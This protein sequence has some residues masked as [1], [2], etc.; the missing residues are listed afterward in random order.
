MAQFSG[1]LL[2]ELAKYGQVYL[3]DI[4]NSTQIQARKLAKE[5]FLNNGYGIKAIVIANQQT[6]GFGRFGRVWYSPAQGLYF[7]LLVNFAHNECPLTLWT[8]YTAKIIAD[9]IEDFTAIPIYL[10]W[11]NDLV[12]ID[13]NYSFYKVGGILAETIGRSLFSVKSDKRL[14]IIGVG[15]NINQT[16]FPKELPDATS[17]KLINMKTKQIDTD[18]NQ[19]E[20]LHQILKAM[21]DGLSYYL[22]H[23]KTEIVRQ[24]K[25]KSSVIGKRVKISRRFKTLNGTAIDI[26]EYGRLVLRTDIGRIITLDAGEIL[27]IR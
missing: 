22:Q 11:P 27:S 2:S 18:F 24:I 1:E 23:P 10:K 5:S 9:V 15:I 13:N 19:T 17:L 3:F 16:N 26:D 25:D 4:I 8:L 21:A 12:Y 6:K 14:M 20:I 7:S